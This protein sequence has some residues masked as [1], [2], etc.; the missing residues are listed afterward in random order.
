MWECVCVCVAC[1]CVIRNLRGCASA[2]LLRLLAP[3]DDSLDPE[4]DTLSV[5]RMHSYGRK[6]YCSPEPSHPTSPMR[7]DA[8]PRAGVPIAPTRSPGNP[9]R[10]PSRIDSHDS[11]DDSDHDSDAANLRCNKMQ[12]GGALVSRTRFRS[13]R[14]RAGARA[15]PEP[16][17][18]FRLPESVRARAARAEPGVSAG[19]VRAMEGCP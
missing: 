1:V 3:I 6:I 9:S 19:S 5:G 10:G 7:A 8:V 16:I 17:R 18:V 12:S 14:A 4:S 2:L 11:D 13:R 15:R